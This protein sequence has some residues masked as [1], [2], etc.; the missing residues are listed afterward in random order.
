M[1]RRA[2]DSAEFEISAAFEHEI[3]RFDGHLRGERGFSEHTRRAYATDLRQLAGF[4]GPAAEPATVGPD[5][6]R[7]FLADCH[8]RLSPATVGRKLASLRSFFAHLVREGVRGADPSLGIPGPRQPRRLPRP[9]SVDDCH[10]LAD[11]PPQRPGAGADED[12]PGSLRDHAI[13][14]LLYGAGLRVA[15]LCGLDRG[16]IDVH[17]GRV[18]VLGKGGRERVVPLPAGAHEA[19]AAHLGAGGDPQVPAFVALRARRGEEPRRL[20]ARDVRRILLRLARDANVAD[21]VHPHRLRHSY[22]THLLDMGADLREIQ[23]LLGHRSL[24]TTQKY[25]AVSS[26]R[27]VAVYDQAHPRAR[28]GARATRPRGSQ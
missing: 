18:R 12:S 1:S 24:S 17:R 6:V 22:A 2:R 14:E 26:E 5:E 28:K 10:A 3:E 25:T 20:G 13:V 19:V 21:R 4:L 9:L 23:E 8:G 15:E 11:A 27:L 7:A 16:A